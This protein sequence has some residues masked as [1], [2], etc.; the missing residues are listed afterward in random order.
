MKICR[1]LIEDM[2]SRNICNID[3]FISVN[4]NRSMGNIATATVS[5]DNTNDKQYRKEL[6][7]D[8]KLINSNRRYWHSLLSK[9]TNG[10]SEKE[11]SIRKIFLYSRIWID[12]KDKDAKENGW[13]PC[14]T[15]II[16]SVDESLIYGSKI[17]LSLGCVELAHY[18]KQTIIPTVPAAEKDLNTYMGNFINVL[19]LSD[20]TYT[21]SLS[22]KS[23][24]EILNNFI[25]YANSFNTFVGFN[26]A[27]DKLKS[28]DKAEFNKIFVDNGWKDCTDKTHWFRH[29]ALWGK[30]RIEPS[31]TVFR[32]NNR[33]VYDIPVGEFE[34]GSDIYILYDAPSEFILDN[35]VGENSTIIQKI[36]TNT[37]VLY[38]MK[39]ES[40]WAL[41]SSLSKILF[42]DLFTTG[43]GDIVLQVPRY[44]NLPSF[45]KNIS[46]YGWGNIQIS[47][48]KE[49]FIVKGIQ[50]N[51]GSNYILL[52]KDIKGWSTNEDVENI[53]TNIAVAYDFNYVSSGDLGETLAS[54]YF[55]GRAIDTHFSPMNY[56]FKLLSIDKIFALDID[57]NNLDKVKEN[58]SLK[59]IFAK[60]LLQ[61]Y[62]LRYKTGSI[63]LDWRVDL[64][65]G[66]TVYLTERQLLGYISG[67][68]MSYTVG[69]SL[70]T[71]YNISNVHR[72]SESIGN[73]WID[74]LELFGL[75]TKV[76]TSQIIT[77]YNSSE[78]IIRSNKEVLPIKNKDFLLYPIKNGY[79]R[80]SKKKRLAGQIEIVLNNE[81][82]CSIRA[83][84]DGEVT[85]FN[86]NDYN[87]W[88]IRIKHVYRG[89]I[90]SSCYCHLNKKLYKSVM[91]SKV[92]RGEI[93]GYLGN[94][95]NSNDRYFFFALVEIDRNGKKVPIKIENTYKLVDT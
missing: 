53:N 46:D 15:G 80:V 2:S 23:L 39:K 27:Y 87:K 24:K 68:K 73:Y 6:T 5:L 18:L 26:T 70:S 28:K 62:N 51:H 40:I 4:I 89:K 12:V 83:I 79:T 36:I 45:E 42:L 1:V 82:D 47:A 77:S 41:I 17:E 7:N 54:L 85:E 43:A 31:G 52:A 58:T 55:T 76:I 72:V 34:P 33:P 78:T 16:T 95:E 67:F 19:S 69:E 8:E 94:S 44:D 48:K 50:C 35:I 63:D 91:G 57:N 20:F 88:F 64:E 14:F 13:M 21:S 65:L 56:G 22:S 32:N 25:G 90:L 66:K 81:T 3:T 29:S 86:Y 9:Y 11:E 74:I 71:S 61:Y 10:V 84:Y 75:S 59:N 30:L 93:I 38:G 49:K 92:K 60:H 37:I